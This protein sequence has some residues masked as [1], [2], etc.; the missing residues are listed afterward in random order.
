MVEEAKGPELM[1]RL[2]FERRYETIGAVCRD[3][4][5]GR[6]STAADLLDGD[7]DWF[8]GVHHVL[9]TERQIIDQ[10]TLKRIFV[11]ALENARV[12]RGLSP[13]VSKLFPIPDE[14]EARGSELRKKGIRPLDEQGL[15]EILRAD[16][17]AIPEATS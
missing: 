11:T 8:Y 14:V 13:S 7:S 6:P 16:Y 17:P 9:V 5:D 15:I 10:E 1:D 3:M 2:W 12:I 4:F